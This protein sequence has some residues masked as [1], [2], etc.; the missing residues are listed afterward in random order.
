MGTSYKIIHKPGTFHCYTFALRPI[1]KPVSRP[2][3]KALRTVAVVPAVCRGGDFSAV[4]LVF[5]RH[6]RKNRKRKGEQYY[7]PGIR[8]FRWHRNARSFKGLPSLRLMHF[9]NM[10]YTKLFKNGRVYQRLGFGKGVLNFAMKDTV[11][12]AIN[13][14][15]TRYSRNQKQLSRTR[16]TVIW[17]SISRDGSIGNCN[18]T[19]SSHFK[20]R[21]HTNISSPKMAYHGMSLSQFSVVSQIPKS[22][23]RGQMDRILDSKHF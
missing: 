4:L 11:T 21:G 3:L 1:E 22:A 14:C 16:L 7:V 15:Y 9:W 10:V 8:W 2:P 18:V 20:F 17:T 6:G 23:F 19:W 5:Y 12:T 13:T